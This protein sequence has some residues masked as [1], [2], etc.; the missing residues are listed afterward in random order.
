MANS[1]IIDMSGKKIGR[2]SVI[3]Q[4]GNGK[5]GCALWLC[6]C[7]CGSEGVVSG[8]N[9][10]FGKSNQCKS[11]AT[12]EKN[13][14]HGLSKT[15]L[16]SIYSVM[17]S[18]CYNKN[19]HKYKSYGERGITICEEWLNDFKNFN[20]WAISSGYNDDL[21]IDRID[22][23]KGYSPDNCRWATAQMQSENRRFVAKDEN[24]KLWWHVAKENNITQAAYRSRLSDG[25]D[26]KDAATRPMRKRGT[27]TA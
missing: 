2:W 23:E 11:C 4:E 26:I 24:G 15:R 12:A 5:K 18:R 8:A 9:L 20:D 25:W 22:N 14:T 7:E 19:F 17:K 6:I 21:T 10:R 3:K 16:F 27:S 1:R 13:T